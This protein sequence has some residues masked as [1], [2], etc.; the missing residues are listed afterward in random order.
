[1]WSPPYNAILR[2]MDCIIVNENRHSKDV[3]WQ[4]CGQNKEDTLFIRNLE[5]VVFSANFY[6]LLVEHEVEVWVIGFE[7][8]RVNVAFLVAPLDPGNTIH[9][10]FNEA[11]IVKCRYHDC[12]R[13][14][15]N[16]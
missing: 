5:Q 1:M 14:R 11:F 3:H 8:G 9:D 7:T 6:P 15:V 16:N 2:F 4:V 12:C 10:P 13:T